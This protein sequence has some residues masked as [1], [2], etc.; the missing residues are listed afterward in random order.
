[1]TVA[2]GERRVPSLAAWVKLSA[3]FALVLGV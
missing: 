3:P 2:V 1:V